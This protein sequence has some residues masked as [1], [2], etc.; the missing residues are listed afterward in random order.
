MQSSIAVVSLKVGLLLMG[1]TVVGCSALSAPGAVER[2]ALS[3]ESRCASPAVVRCF[4]FDSQNE[5]DRYV[6]PPWGEKVKLAVVD[7]TVKASGAGSLRFEVPPYSGDD[8]SGSFKLNF[9]DDLSVQFGEGE[10]FY[11][12]W[13]QRFSPDFLKTYF[14]GGFGWKQIIIGEGDRPGF[15]SPG[16]TQLEIVVANSN[17]LGYPQ[18]YH[19]C[20]AKDGQFEQLG[21]G[22]SYAADEWM[23]FQVHVRIGTW[24]K[25][26]RRYHHDSTVQLWVGRDGRE[27]DL[28]INFTPEESNLFGMRIPGTGN[29]YDIANDTPEAKYGKLHL[30]PYHTRKSPLQQ[31]PTGYVWYDDLIISKQRIPDPN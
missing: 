12:Q 23:T 3:F 10:E 19:S 24:Y 15:T 25:N 4:G 17:Q 5:T 6:H 31:H 9:H 18:A 7:T 21:G 22:G 27:S 11:V 2:A 28:V 16:C 13:R 8:S 29:G 20:G 1:S 30:T 26:D 14:D